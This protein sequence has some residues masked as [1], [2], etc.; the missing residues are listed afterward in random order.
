MDAFDKTSVSIIELI[1]ESFVNREKELEVI[2]RTIERHTPLKIASISGDGGSGKT[3]LMYKAMMSL[4][5]QGRYHIASSAIDFYSTEFHSRGGIRKGIVKSLGE[6]HFPKFT[7]LVKDIQNLREASGG[8]E[9]VSITSLE[10]SAADMFVEEYKTL[11]NS[12]HVVLAFD[13]F[14]LVQEQPVARW[15]FFELLPKLEGTCVI[16]SGRRTPD[17]AFHNLADI[18]TAVPIR[19]FEREDIADLF[20]K[21]GIPANT[22]SEKMFTKIVEL[23]HGSPLLVELAIDWLKED[24]DF[25]KILNV[26]N[27]KN[28]EENLV[29]AIREFRDPRYHA[30]L[31]LSWA[32]RRCDTQMLKELMADRSINYDELIKTLAKLSFVKY[33][34]ALDSIL[35]HDIM[36]ELVVK[37]VW[38]TVDPTAA[39][40]IALS[41]RIL[42]HYRDKLL[43][44]AQS[45]YERSILNAEMVFYAAYTD[46]GESYRHFAQVFDRLA[47]S[48]RYDDCELLLWEISEISR[49]VGALPPQQQKEVDVRR[50][51]LMLFRHQFSEALDFIE[52]FIHHETAAE[53]KLQMYLV[54]ADYYDRTGEVLKALEDREVAVNLAS[55]DAVDHNDRG[56]AYS[57]RGYSYRI[58]GRWDDA[59]A[60]LQMA[61]KY[62][63]DLG[64]VSNIFNTIGYI[65][66]LKTDYERALQYCEAGLK[67][68][69]QIGHRK[70]E[71]WSLSTIGEVYRYKGVYLKALQY[72]EVA[73]KIFSEGP[74]RENQARVYQQRGTCY[75]VMK[76]FEKAKNDFDLA[77]TYYKSFPEH[78][79]YP[80]A[81]SRYGRFFQ[82]QNQH[83]EARQQFTLALE[84]S[85]KISDV[86]TEVYTLFRLAQTSYMLGQPIQ[87]LYENL[88]RMSKIMESPTYQNK[89]HLGQMN[90]L[91]AHKLFDEEKYEE[92]MRKYGEGIAL[93]ATQFHSS[94]YLISDYLNEI[95]QRMD[96]LNSDQRIEWCEAMQARWK[97]GDLL[98]KH[99]ELEA[100]CEIRRQTATLALQQGKTNELSKKSTTRP[101]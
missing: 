86:D 61:I 52:R 55:D 29:A 49:S 10:N 91:I 19:P 54:R 18:V 101:S 17:F 62:S 33:R 83:E 74:D 28:F 68:R 27:T 66:S 50:A 76:E 94:S 42:S 73:L 97:E 78:R 13:T 31:N 53:F 69:E 59:I 24:F 9:S 14:E 51:K 47:N 81:L 38:A 87:K 57:E 72:F 98:V 79:E 25:K 30:I 82:Y 6:Q 88:D 5:G 46:I 20:Q 70:G 12:R 95:S 41:Q 77:F 60:S 67:L 80:R 90:I 40:R 58:V 21:R 48:L 36:R 100:F 84:L 2:K 26:S 4:T 43:P 15:L 22:L 93:I 65:F 1:Q 39:A 92:A 34:K 8:V 99:P 71:A 89:Q 11:T 7:T 16:L 23:T 96:A 3:W 32:Y 44:T 37:Y 64:E 63:T 85:Q 75:A 56:K 45:H 35:L